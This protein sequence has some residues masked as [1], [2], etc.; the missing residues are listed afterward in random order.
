MIRKWQ[1][2]LLIAWVWFWGFSIVSKIGFVVPELVVGG[3]RFPVGFLAPVAI[4]A[5]SIVLFRRLKGAR[6]LAT[7]ILAWTTVRLIGFHL[8]Y[9]VGATDVHLEAANLIAGLVYYLINGS[10]LN[11]LWRDK[12][13]D[14]LNRK[15]RQAAEAETEVFD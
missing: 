8:R 7:A 10:C 12:G 15:S 9:I 3:L 13:G 1:T 6:W 14:P 5:G 4:I 2:G 11:Y